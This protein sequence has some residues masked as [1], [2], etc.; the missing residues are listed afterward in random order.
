MCRAYRLARE[1]GEGLLMV[2]RTVS[3]VARLT[4]RCLCGRI[5]YSARAAPIGATHCHCTMCR[6]ASG[7]AF[8]TWVTFR[9]DDVAYVDGEPRYLRS[10]S[11]AERGCC[12]DCGSQMT[13]RYHSEPDRL[14]FSI[15]TF[16]DAARI[17]P[18]KHI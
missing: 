11:I 9:L 16:D 17:A 7:S 1:A 4:G 13:M 14:A 2:Q 12:P 5:R 8:A 3:D 6:R 10:S 15:G 18:R